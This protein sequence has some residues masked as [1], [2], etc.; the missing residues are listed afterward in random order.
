MSVRR[1]RLLVIALV[2]S[3]AA[4]S[5]DFPFVAGHTAA[6]PLRPAK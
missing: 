5:A 4:R 1:R 6:A 3:T 2:A